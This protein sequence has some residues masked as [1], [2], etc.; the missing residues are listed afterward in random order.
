MPLIGRLQS[1]LARGLLACA[2]VLLAISVA[3]AALH[4]VLAQNP[5]GAPRPAPT[6]EPEASGII[7]WLLAKQSEFYRQM[8]STIRA[9]KSDGSAVWTLLF[10]SFAYGV[11]HAAGPGHGKAVIASYLV[12]NRETAR[13]GIALSFA[14]AL[15]QSLVA[16]LIVGISAWVLNATA[17]TMCKAE[18]AIEIASY[19]LIALFGLRLVWVKGRTFIRALQAAQPVPAI[20]GVPHHHDHHHDAH[21]H[22]DHDHHHHDQDHALTHAPDGH[23]HVHD[24][25]CGHSHGP[26]PRELAGPG[27]WRRGFAAILTV[28]I[29]PCSGAILVLVFALAQGLFWAGI[30]ATFLMGLGTAITVAAIAVVAVSAKDIAARLSA[31]RDGGGALFMRGIEFAAAGVV[32]LFGA[33]LLFGYIAAERT[34]CF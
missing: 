15:M 31:G 8:S 1:P 17:K 21:D 28:G 12:A 29:R 3:D 10:I 23:G 22:H 24:E 14:S 4:D 16:I 18:G 6:A 9:A 13:R 5:F 34:T 11:F 20:A 25:H 33:G 30:A 32:L 26:T 19:A 27:G 2:A 7:G